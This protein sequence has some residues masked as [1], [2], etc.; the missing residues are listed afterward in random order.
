LLVAIEGTLGSLGERGG[1]R[2]GAGADGPSPRPRQRNT[3]SR[4][5]RA[6]KALRHGKAAPGYRG[7][8]KLRKWRAGRAGSSRS[9]RRRRE[10]RPVMRET[11]FPAQVAS[12]GEARRPSARR[13]GS[14]TFALP[15]RRRKPPI[16]VEHELL[17]APGDHG[18]SSDRRRCNDLPLSRGWPW[19]GAT[20]DRVPFA[21]RR[22]ITSASPVTGALST[23]SSAERGQDVRRR[24][25]E[26]SGSGR[27][28]RA[29]GG[30]ARRCVKKAAHDGRDEPDCG[31]A[32]HRA[33]LGDP[34][35]RPRLGGD[36]PVLVGLDGGDDV[37]HFAA[38]TPRSSSSSQESRSP[39][40]PRRRTPSERATS[41]E[42]STRGGR[43]ASV[44]KAGR[45]LRHPD[46]DRSVWRLSKLGRAA[47][48]PC[49]DGTERVG[50]SIVHPTGGR[51]LGRA[52]GRKRPSGSAA[53]SRDP[54]SAITGTCPDCRHA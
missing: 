52:G 50:A 51:T 3:R 43:P 53:E 41:S 12:A 26:T 18:T 8:S 29:R 44:R 5:L 24:S 47:G 37:A 15:D 11:A 35:A 6:W 20:S 21:A 27:R 4:Y 48:R 28:R 25:P 17:R 36:E 46:A 10:P 54:R 40:R 1:R 2:G 32:L 33:A 45:R 30:A 16:R 14:R 39:S 42:H 34:E 9:A 49:R 23:A 7:Q 22:R 13:G 38:L 31:L 19:S